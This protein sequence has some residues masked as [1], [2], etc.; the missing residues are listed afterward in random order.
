M[1]RISPAKLE[2]SKWTAAQPAN[3]EKHWLVT[4]LI[5]DDADNVT[6]CVI[7]AVYSKRETTIDW[8]ELQDSDRWQQ[9]WK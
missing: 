5:R 2:N 7:E 1:N 4:K 6:G 8:R 3:K 9:G